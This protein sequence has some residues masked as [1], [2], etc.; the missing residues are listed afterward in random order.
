MLALPSPLRCRQNGVPGER[1]DLVPSG[2]SLPALVA[3]RAIVPFLP[4][5][6]N[7]S[8]RKTWAKCQHP[9]R[10]SPCR[11]AVRP[12]PQG[13]RSCPDGSPSLK[14]L[15]GLGQ[16]KNVPTIHLAFFRGGGSAALVTSQHHAIS[17]T[18]MALA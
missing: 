11:P 9:R 4:L 18:K 1:L 16:E 3:D 14:Q 12:P 15:R 10:P 6:C 17:S 5:Y 2:S 8:Y 13:L 7:L